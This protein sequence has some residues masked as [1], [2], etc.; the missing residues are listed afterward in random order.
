VSYNI[1]MKYLAPLNTWVY[2]WFRKRFYQHVSHIHCPSAFTAEQLRKHKYKARL[3]IVSNGVDEAFHPMEVEKPEEWKNTYVIAMVGRLSAE[4]RQ[5]LIIKAVLKSKYRNQIQLVFPGKGPKEKKYRKLGAKLKNPPVFSYYKKEDLARILNQCDLYVHASEAE[6]EGI[7]CIEAISCG[8]VPIISDSKKSATKQFALDKRCLFKNRSARDLCR[9]IEYMIEHPEEMEELREKYLNNAKRH[10]ISRSVEKMVRIYE[11]II[12]E[13]QYKEKHKNDPDAHT[14]HMPTTLT[15]DVG[16]GYRFVNRNALFLVVS[17]LVTYFIIFPIFYFITA[18]F[19][20]YRAKGRKN[21]R[22]VRDGAVTVSNHAHILDAPM[23]AFSLFPRK[24]F[25]TTLKTNMEIPFIGILVR[26]LG[27][28]PIPETPKALR[29][30]MASMSQELKKGRLVHFYP[31]AALWM[32]HNELRPFKNGAFHLAVE[33]GKPVLPMVLKFREPGWLMKRIK[34]KPMVS[35]VIGP[36]VHLPE[37]GTLKERAEWL[38]NSVHDEME[39]LL[40]GTT[41]AKTGS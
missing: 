9:K 37:G 16:S 38:R 17:T 12:E 33:S 32:G 21:L 20:G 3:H 35:I 7:P 40:K 24:P 25:M 23:I 8:L 10:R 14:I 11:N 6:I 2:R 1:G 22:Q 30:F 13:K 28:V 29:A 5:D 39:K 27:G 36:P 4:K 31:E 41:A 19:L 26:M 15:Y 18:V 34:K